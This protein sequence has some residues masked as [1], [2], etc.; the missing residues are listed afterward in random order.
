MHSRDVKNANLV[1]E[2]LE[3][4]KKKKKKKTQN[5]RGRVGAGSRKGKRETLLFS[6]LF[7]EG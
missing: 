2:H 5:G 6:N 3:K 1:G 4:K 7:S